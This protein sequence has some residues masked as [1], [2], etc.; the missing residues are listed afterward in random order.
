MED[1]VQLATQ[2]QRHR[3]L[4]NGRLSDEKLEQAVK[5]SRQLRLILEDVLR[6]HH[7]SGRA[8]TRL[9]RIARTLADLADRETVGP[10][11]LVEAA[12]LRGYEGTQALG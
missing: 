6:V 3:G 12:R 4:F 8:R 5:P 2:R 9:L 7:L 1:L 11:D 10:E